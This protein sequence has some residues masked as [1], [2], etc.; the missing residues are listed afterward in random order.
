MKA[1]NERRIQCA[2]H[3]IMTFACPVPGAPLRTRIEDHTRQRF[4]AIDRFLGERIG[5]PWRERPRLVRSDPAHTPR[6]DLWEFALQ[7]N[8]LLR[9]YKAG[10]LV[11][12]LTGRMS[13]LTVDAFQFQS[14]RHP[15]C[16]LGASQPVTDDLATAWHPQFH[17]RSVFP[18][19]TDFE[20]AWQRTSKAMGLLEPYPDFAELVWGECG[21]ICFISADPAMDEG[22]CISLASKMVPGL[23][24]VSL[25]PPI[26]LAESLVHEAAH[27][28]FRALEEVTELYAGGPDVRLKTPLRADPRPVSGLM[29][30]LVVLRHLVA[31]YEKLS[32]SEEAT[33]ARQRP[34][35]EKRFQ[36]HLQDLDAGKR[37]AEEAAPALTSDGRELLD[38]LLEDS[39]STLL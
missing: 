1:R 28:R 7:A 11:S 31:L 9:L 35:V 25:A 22:H 29:H 5:S 27:L 33:V 14:E 3:Q 15:L 37:M 30:Q 38:R 18:G 34:Q 10:R 23:V 19:C 32:V 39:E 36:V 16:L 20:D 26:L 17:G 12:D 4:G 2:P 6:R 24:Y 8:V 13:A 21:A